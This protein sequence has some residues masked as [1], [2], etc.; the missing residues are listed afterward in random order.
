MA[1]AG[2][3]LLPQLLLTNW[4][5]AAVL[6]ATKKAKGSG[7]CAARAKCQPQNE[8]S[9]NTSHQAK[10][11]VDESEGE[12]DAERGNKPLTTSK[13]TWAVIEIRE[14]GEIYELRRMCSYSEIPFLCVAHSVLTSPSIIFLFCCFARSFVALAGGVA[15]AEIPIA[16]MSGPLSEKLRRNKAKAMNR[17][18]R[19]KKGC[20]TYDSIISHMI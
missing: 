16:A 18:A 5:V 3:S 19:G 15:E 2:V 13:I 8:P 20:Y 7:L 6:S 9:R 12:S 11:K 1:L 10:E 4:E 17:T 14:R